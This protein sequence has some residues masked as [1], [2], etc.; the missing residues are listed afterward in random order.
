[1]DPWDYMRVY[2]FV[3]GSNRYESLLDGISLNGSLY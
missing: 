1:M 3:I 2:V